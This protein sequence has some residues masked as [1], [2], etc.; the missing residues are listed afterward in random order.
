[1][2]NGESPNP[3]AVLRTAKRLVDEAWAVRQVSVGTVNGRRLNQQVQAWDKPTSGVI[4][5]NTNAPWIEIK[6]Q[7][8]EAQG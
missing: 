5:I 1:M 8:R 7:I 2:N 4:K 3:E 6:Q